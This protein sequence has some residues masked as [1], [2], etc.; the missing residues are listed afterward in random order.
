MPIGLAPSNSFARRRVALSP[1]P[2]LAAV[3]HVLRLIAPHRGG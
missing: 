1:P 3:L 2:P